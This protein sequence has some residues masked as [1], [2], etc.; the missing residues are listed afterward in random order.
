MTKRL[1]VIIGFAAVVAF[2]FYIDWAF[3]DRDQKEESEY[4]SPRLPTYLFKEPSEEQLMRIAR[5]LARQT[6]TRRGRLGVLSQGE[7]GLI[8]IDADQDMKIIE[9]AIKALRERGADA[10]Y[11]YDYQLLMSEM[12]L[13]EKEA[14]GRASVGGRRQVNQARPSNFFREGVMEALRGYGPKYFPKELLDRMPEANLERINQNKIRKELLIPALKSYLDKRPEYRYAFVGFWS[15]GPLRRILHNTLGDRFQEGWRYPDMTSLITNSVAFPADLWRALEEKVMEIIPWVQ[16][17]HVTDPEGTDLRYSVSAE[18]AELWSTRPY[19]EDYIMLY[20]LQATAD[21]YLYAD[22]W[23]TKRVKHHVAP[24]ANGVIVGTFNHT[25]TYPRMKV[26]V[27][28][29][30]VQKVEGGG[31]VGDQ[32]RTFLQ[33]RFR[34]AHY[35]YHPRPGFLYLYQNTVSVNPKGVRD[36]R[37]IDVG[38]AGLMVWGFGAESTIPEVV[39]FAEKNDLPLWHRFHMHQYFPTYEARLRGT[40]ETIKVVDKG[41]LMAL[42]DPEI[43]ALASKYGKA[44]EILDVDWIPAIPGVNVPGDYEKDYGADPSV[45]FKKEWSQIEAGTY[46]YW[47]DKPIPIY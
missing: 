37:G 31:R 34:E 15:S 43:R 25:G 27:Q 12:G 22:V 18:E 20:P 38:R 42:D 21:L 29:G 28:D 26:T 45:Y 30:V 33:E 17:V 35:P 23:K 6:E 1:L 10:D 8:V 39:E 47:V 24:K 44:G 32:M 11:V 36:Y 19:F 46:P 4:A 5:G 16:E 7:K 13:S 2:S 14:R 41:H 40:D 9:A 3:R